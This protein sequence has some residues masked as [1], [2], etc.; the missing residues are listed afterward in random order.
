MAK[1]KKKTKVPPYQN[2]VTS[3]KPIFGDTVISVLAEANGDGS[4]D[5][6]VDSTKSGTF[7][8]PSNSV[9]TTGTITLGGCVIDYVVQFYFQNTRP[10]F[11]LGLRS[12]CL[13]PPGPTYKWFKGE[14]QDQEQGDNT[15]SGLVTFATGIAG[16]ENFTVTVT[17]PDQNG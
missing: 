2:P 7:Q 15:T 10:I 13:N 12:D 16:F 17:Y 14:Q 3:R 8:T 9:N 4:G 1:R 11:V 6:N 5:N